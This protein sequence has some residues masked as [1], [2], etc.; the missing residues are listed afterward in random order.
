MAI[1]PVSANNEAQA[2]DLNQY[3]NH[4]QGATG[5]TEAYHFRMAGGA[6]F[7]ITLSD[8]VGARKVSIRDSGGN[9]VASIDSDGGASFASLLLTL[10]DIPTSASPSQTALGRAVWDSANQRLTVGNGTGR[11]VFYPGAPDV[12]VSATEPTGVTAGH[13]WVDIT[14]PTAPVLNVFAEEA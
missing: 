5:A 9:E 1:L 2:D 11:E 13:L 12:T 4:L 14:D 7:I 3:R 10:L 6:D 8:A